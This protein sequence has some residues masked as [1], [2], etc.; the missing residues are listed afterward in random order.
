[1]TQLNFTVY[2]AR[3]RRRKNSMDKAA[4][5]R[6]ALIRYSQVPDKI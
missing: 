3:I 1:M 6:F 5:N 2:G 4:L